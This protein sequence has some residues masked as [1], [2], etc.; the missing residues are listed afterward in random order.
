MRIRNRARMEDG[1]LKSGGGGPTV[2]DT[3]VVVGRSTARSK[4]SAVGRRGAGAPNLGL[5][6]LSYTDECRYRTITRSRFL[7]LSPGERRGVLRELYW[8]N[9]RRLQW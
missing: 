9:L 8:D 6:C 2:G 7:A 4:E 5:V 1:E 3:E